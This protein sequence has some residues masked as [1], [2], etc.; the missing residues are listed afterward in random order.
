MTFA[1]N[2]RGTELSIPRCVC[3]T[4]PKR[5]QRF[6]LGY[7][8]AAVLAHI[9]HRCLYNKPKMTLKEII[10]EA[11][12]TVAKIF[13]GDE[14]IGELIS[15][16]N[17]AIELSENNATDINNIP[18]MSLNYANRT[19]GA[20]DFTFRV[21]D[22]AGNVNGA[23][24]FKDAINNYSFCSIDPNNPIP[25][26]TSTNQWSAVY[27]QSY[28][29]NGTAWGLD[30]ANVWTAGNSFQTY[31]GL[32]GDRNAFIAPMWAGA[33]SGIAFLTMDATKQFVF[34]QRTTD[35][36]SR[37]VYDATKGFLIIRTGETG[38]NNYVDVIPSGND[39]RLGD[40]TN[41]WKTLNGINPGALSL[42]G[43][44]YVEIDTTNWNLTGADNLYI[45][46]A[47]GYIFCGSNTCTD[48]KLFD[49]TTRLG[50][51]SHS[52]TSKENYVYLP[53]SK[54]DNCI[55]GFVGTS[56]AFRFYPC[57]GNV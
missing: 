15:A 56:P 19:T 22:S 4:W 20:R 49:F 36:N 47:D 48:I 54:N 10:I 7:M 29:Y 30:K 21:Y 25:L 53:V 2:V 43:S 14:H 16:I 34:G 38:G 1:S 52:N 51:T 41:K 50:A 6:A 17:D 3:A 18:L 40:S 23:G 46:P 12:D 24:V 26:G 57:L 35:A 13:V 5:S 11:R 28:Y 44:T 39:T 9:V 32:N 31:I 8:P 27:A 42:P 45:P 55:V 33:A 37:Y